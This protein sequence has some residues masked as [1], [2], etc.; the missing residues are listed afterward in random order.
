MSQAFQD[1]GAGASLEEV[2][3]RL[4][5]WMREGTEDGFLTMRSR[6]FGGKPCTTPYRAFLEA[7][8]VQP[9]DIAT[10]ED[11]PFL[12]V[13]VFKSHD[14]KSG[15]W[16]PARVPKSGTTQTI[17]RAQ[18]WMDDEGLAWYAQ[19]SRLA[20]QAQWVDPWPIG[21]GWA[22]FQATSDVRMPRC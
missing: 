7:M 10:L 8:N 13:E 15:T 18:H 19:V 17:S 5:S 3:S 12:P 16:S 22:C 4:W 1:W 2:R 6:C 9:E 21:H 14:V 11:I 20:W